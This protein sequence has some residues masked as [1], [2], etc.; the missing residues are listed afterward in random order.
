MHPL[1]VVPS[2][3]A[4]CGTPKSAKSLILSVLS[5]VIPTHQLLPICGSLVLNLETNSMPSESRR[6]PRAEIRTWLA[7]TEQQVETDDAELA[8]KLVPVDSNIETTKPRSKRYT[9]T[10]GL[11]HEVRKAIPVQK[12]LKPSGR[13]RAGR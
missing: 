10:E 3:S 8:T 11:N 6:S 9:N 4:R 1:K 7:R 13:K 12:E 2:S 5:Q